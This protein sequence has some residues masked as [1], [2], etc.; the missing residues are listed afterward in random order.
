MLD[1][2]TVA[3]DLAALRR[4]AEAGIAD[5]TFDV[6]DTA[7]AELHR[8]GGLDRVDAGNWLRTLRA[9]GVR[10]PQPSL[11]ELV[12]SFPDDQDILEFVAAELWQRAETRAADAESDDDDLAREAWSAALKM[13]GP[14]PRTDAE[15]V[16][17]IGLLDRFFQAGRRQ[18]TPIGSYAEF[19]SALKR[20]AA[21]GP[22]ST[23]RAADLLAAESPVTALELVT[24]AELSAAAVL[25]RAV[26]SAELDDF[27]TSARLFDQLAADW[28]VG[29][30]DLDVEDR[31]RWVQAMTDVGRFAEAEEA[32]LRTIAVVE[33]RP[34]DAGGWTAAGM[35]QDSFAHWR[36]VYRLLAYRLAA[37]QGHF[38]AAW[39]HLRKSVELDDTSL[40]DE[41]RRSI[42]RIRILLA[43]QPMALAILAEL[44]QLDTPDPYN[45]SYAEACLWAG[46]QWGTP[47]SEGRLVDPD[48]PFAGSRYTGQAAARAL[49]AQA[50]PEVD[51]RQL[52]RLA[53]LAGDDDRAATMIAAEPLTPAD[54]WSVQVLGAMLL[55]RTGDD[56]A[57]DAL[58]AQ[59]LPLRRHDLDLR[60][61]DAQASL[62]AGRYKEAMREAMA[63]TDAVGEHILARTIQAEGE[64]ESALA[65]AEGPEGGTGNTGSVENAQ[66]LMVA[67]ADYRMAADLHRDTRYYLETGRARPG[68]RV[69]SE[70]LAPRLFIEVCRRG[71]HAAI[72]AQEGLDR[73]GLKGDAQLIDD[74]QDLV[75]HLRS[76]NQPCC[77]TWGPRWRRLVH[78]VRHLPD[79]DEASRLALLMIAYRWSNWR[80]RLVNGAFLLLG[81]VVTYLGLTNQLPGPE[82]DTLRVMVLGVGVLLLL[83]PFARSLKVGVV[84]LSR[85]A[86]VAPLSGR[87]KSLRTSR[88]L[89]RANHL[90]TFALPSPP[91]KGRRAHARSREDGAPSTSPTA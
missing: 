59:V 89:L 49:L 16:R 43:D 42:L 88:L 55:L 77:R 29:V 52:L 3:A 19:E 40:P 11:A 26:A 86:D 47:T 70:P 30:R 65:M 22:E 71:L 41:L 33:G 76:V 24:G 37:Q 85:D 54:P 50:G 66:Q 69:G 8:L 63:I 53:L 31:S 90:G 81:V 57:A 75:Q 87:S 73:L 39:D 28:G 32:C 56:V 74:A 46:T 13:A 12:A 1:Q 5:G 44:R 21:A 25:V 4:R 14:V 10:R 67:V 6:A 80:K 91:E 7:Y 45:T 83:M 64:F 34:G 15:G 48:N 2:P 62:I 61:L 58:L 35:A 38:R 79:R 27:T 72:L 84:E 17:L 78:Q 82:S 23:L 9:L 36:H 68:G 51:S 20:F 60:V 18:R